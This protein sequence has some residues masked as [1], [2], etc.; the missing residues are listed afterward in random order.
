MYH[1]DRSRKP[2]PEPNSAGPERI[3][4]LEKL[5]NLSVAMLKTATA[6]MVIRKPDTEVA[7]AEVAGGYLA[8]SG[9]DVPLTRAIGVGTTGPINARDIASVENFFKTRNSPVSIVISERT[10]PS[11]Q[12]LLTT[13]GYQANDY[14]QNWWLDLSAAPDPVVLNGIEVVPVSRSESELWVRTVA[15]GFAETESSLEESEL[16]TPMLDVFYCLGFA[17]GAQPFL[18]RRNGVAVGGGVLHISEGTAQIRTGSCRFT[19]RR[20]GVQSAILKTRLDAASRAGC[21]LAFSSTDGAG[22]SARNL[23]K[24]GFEPLSVSFRMT[25]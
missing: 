22:P 7:S 21:R 9:S 4:L 3:L 16:P 6:A 23:R 13:R 18:A 10:D 20:M 8:F 1:M 24:F 11:L 5:Q 25:N 15:A 17:D 14:L 12:T 2:E 19:H